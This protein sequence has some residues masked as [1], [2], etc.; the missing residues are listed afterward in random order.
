VLR[1][2]REGPHDVVDALG[3]NE[4]AD[5]PDAPSNRR[6]ELLGARCPGQPVETAT[7]FGTLNS[8]QIAFSFGPQ[9][10]MAQ[11]HAAMAGLMLAAV[12]MPKRRSDSEL[13]REGCHSY[14]KGLFA[15]M[16][17]RREAQ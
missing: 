14:H 9:N 16:Q 10:Y 12:V 8:S 3:T 5:V 13:V 2:E 17:F 11:A 15:V 7:G 1:D 4:P 6:G